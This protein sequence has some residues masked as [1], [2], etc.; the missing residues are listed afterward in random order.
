MV[1]VKPLAAKPPEHPFGVLAE[2]RSPQLRSFSLC[3]EALL[4]QFFDAAEPA[5]H[6]S[7]RYEDERECAAGDEEADQKPQIRTSPECIGNPGTDPAANQAGRRDD[8]QTGDD[9]YQLAHEPDKCAREHQ[10]TSG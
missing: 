2:E 8:C 10:S 6:R 3:D 7:I 9:S 4:V 5:D 1:A